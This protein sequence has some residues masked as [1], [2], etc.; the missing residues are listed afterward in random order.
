LSVGVQPAILASA[1]L[2]LV[3]NIAME[4]RLSPVVGLLKSLCKWTLGA[5]MTILTAI[6]SIQGASLAGYDGISIRTAKYTVDAMVPVVGGML[7]DLAEVL[8][9]GSALVKN[10]VGSLGLITLLALVAQPLLQ[11]AAF[12]LVLRLAGAMAAPL[13]A[14]RISRALDDCAGVAVLWLV[15]LIV[16]AAFLFLLVFITVAAGNAILM[17]R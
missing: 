13:G 3:D 12:L 15:A 14:Q 5:V 6:I 4:Q 16:M 17:Y 8:V 9:A 7:S 1:A 11:V 10:A 2:V